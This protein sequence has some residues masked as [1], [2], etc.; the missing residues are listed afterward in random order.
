[1]S[2]IFAREFGLNKSKSRLFLFPSLS[3][4]SFVDVALTLGLVYPNPTLLN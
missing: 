1:M 2:Q 4:L 3:A